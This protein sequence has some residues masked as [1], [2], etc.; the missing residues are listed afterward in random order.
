M[1]ASRRAGAMRKRS[2][3]RF[4][5]VGDGNCLAETGACALALI[6]EEDLLR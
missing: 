4:T 5:S 2:A 3:F 1:A 6:Q